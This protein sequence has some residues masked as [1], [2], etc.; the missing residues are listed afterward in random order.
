[1]RIKRQ[2]R[3][4]RGKY[5][6]NCLSC[7]AKW[8]KCWYIASIENQSEWET[9][10]HTSVT[11]ADDEVCFQ[12]WDAKIRTSPKRKMHFKAEI[13]TFDAI[14]SDDM[15]YL[16]PAKRT[17]NNKRRAL[18]AEVSMYSRPDAVY[19][20]N[21]NDSK[22]RYGEDDDNDEEEYNDLVDENDAYNKHDDDLYQEGVAFEEESAVILL[23]TGFRTISP[24]HVYLDVD[25]NIHVRVAGT[26]SDEDSVDSDDAKLKKRGSYY[27]GKCG[28]LKKGHMCA[29]SSP[30][31]SS[32]ELSLSCSPS[33]SPTPSPPTHPT[34]GALLAALQS[35]EFQLEDGN[36]L[37]L[38]S[39]AILAQPVVS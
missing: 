5:S 35:A 17:D 27:C 16:R 26:E 38:P 23:S 15:P 14:L 34:H 25:M 32:A 9:R 1:M 12:C 28:Q 4:L 7:T 36:S 21:M 30:L 31:S 33:Q 2:R 24:D 8:S 3:K 11:P 20:Q 29:I 37:E 39:I 22:Q 10:L 6:G 19:T 18:N 13:P